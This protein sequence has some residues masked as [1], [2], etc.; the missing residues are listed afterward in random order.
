MKGEEIMRK[1]TLEY[2]RNQVIGKDSFFNTPYGEKVITYAD[3]TASGKPLK[4]I[5]NY[6]LDIEKYYA[7]SHTEDDVTGESMT[8]LLHKAELIIKKEFNGE[9]NCSVIAA[10]TGA[11]GAVIAFS[12]IIGLYMAPATKKL[13]MN[14]L[15]NPDEKKIIN[16]IF[17]KEYHENAPVVFVGP[18]EHHS[19]ILVWRESLAELV[20]IKLNDEGY[21][22][23]KDLESKVS[24]SKYANRLKIGSFSAGSNVTGVKTPVYDVAK[25]L[26]KYNTLVCFD[27]AASGPYVEIDMNKDQD[28]YF[29]AIYLSPHKFIGGPGSSGILMIN[30]R[31]YDLE[32]PPTTVGGGTVD[33]VSGFG[34]DYVNDIEER[35]KA[36]TPGIIQIIKAALAIQLKGIIGTKTIESIEED[37]TKQFIK[38]FENNNNIEILGPTDPQK[39]LSIIS[40]MVKHNDRYFHPRYI[41]TLLNDLFGIQSRAGCSCAGPYGHKLLDIDDETSEQFRRIIQKGVNSIKPG[42]VRINLHYSMAQETVDFLIDAIEFISVNAKYFLKEYYI[43][44]LSGGWSHLK[45]IEDGASVVNDFGVYCGFEMKDKNIFDEKEIS[46]EQLYR[47]YFEQADSIV[48]SL[49]R[50][51]Y[52]PMGKYED[53]NIEKFNWF[54]FDKAINN[55]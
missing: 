21:L 38:R 20:E 5:E 22:D 15:V 9:D 24:D 43:D 37:Y 36:G 16:Q 14:I 40:F 18:Y 12:K 13:L 39:R 26:H 19:N 30:N 7:N 1:I 50:D 47:M 29:D 51:S 34:H 11:T 46:M 54:L 23:L 52:E 48:D 17:E 55:I 6:L 33:Y 49:K 3:Y 31:V 28:S 42:W 4:F 25:I 32:L 10:G 45:S 35:E 53:E 44:I 41:T 2:L 27:F 8:N